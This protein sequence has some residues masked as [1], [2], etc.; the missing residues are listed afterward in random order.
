MAANATDKF[1]KVGASTV[2]TL[3]APGKAL[4]ATSITVGS[5]TNY[6][7]DTGVT[8]SIR[9]V[10]SNGELDPGTYT[11]WRGTVTSATTIAIEST[12]V[13]GSD[14]VY[15]A[16]STTQ[17]FLQLSASSHN[18]LI[19]GLLASHEQDGLLKSG[20]T[21]KSPIIADDNGNEV[22]KTSTTSSAVNEVTVKNAATGNAP[23]IQA[24]GGDTNVDLRLTPKGTGNVK[25]GATGGAIDWWE[26]LGRTTLSGAGDTIS[27]TPVA[28][29]K[30]LRIIISGLQS[31]SIRPLVRF[32]NDSGNNYAYRTSTNGGADATANTQSAISTIGTGAV[33]VLVV[34]DVVN[35]ASKEKYVSGTYINSATG[36]G[37]A[38]SRI[39]IVGKWVNTSDQI[40]RVDIVNDQAGDFAIGS[41]VVV[42]GH[43]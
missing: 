38:P 31:G 4:A 21:I 12:P 9:V 37:N 34:L 36:A 6:P 19:D 8:V 20:L 2:T 39:E 32:N 27:V 26:E 35:I 16:G 40:T 10:D 42:L 30:H 29:R 14:Q 13:Y 7:T 43:D 25:R 5:T 3:A 23:E 15:A 17:V 24:T 22:V 28:A 41:E 1:K 33:D 18:E 11:E